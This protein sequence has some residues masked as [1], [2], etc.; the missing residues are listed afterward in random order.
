MIHCDHV[1]LWGQLALESGVPYVLDAH[2]EELAAVH[3]ARFHHLAQQAAENAGCILA[4]SDQ[5]AGRLQALFTGLEDRITV[6]TRDAAATSPRHIEEFAARL[7][8]I[9]ERV[10]HDRFGTLPQA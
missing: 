9:Y 7:I 5:M 6:L 4:A 8:G 3:D 2:D 10:L 1:W